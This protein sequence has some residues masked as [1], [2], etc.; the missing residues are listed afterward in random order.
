MLVT[1]EIIMNL[2]VNSGNASSLAIEAIHA[3]R[4]GDFKAADVKLQE[5]SE[6]SI[7]AHNIQTELIQTDLAKENNIEINL[8]LIHAQDHLMNAMTIKTLAVELI[9]ILRANSK[10]KDGEING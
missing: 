6:A 10:T 2:I 3:A 1:E 5:S 9:E 7:K 8:L 4:N